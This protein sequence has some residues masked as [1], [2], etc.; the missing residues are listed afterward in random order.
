[1]SSIMEL[2][3]RAKAAKS[4]IANA[5]T[6]TKN[7][8]LYAI[9][10]E[11]DTQKESILQ[12]N[13]LDVETAKKNGISPSMLDRLSLTEA[14]IDG[15]RDAVLQL[16][17]LPD[18]VG[19]I[20]EGWT[21]PNGLSIRKVTVPL[22]V[23]GMIY[24]ARPNVTVDAATLCLKAG[25]AVMLR[26]GKEAFH[27]SR[28][29]AQLMRAAVQKAGLPEDIIT[30]VEQTD[31]ETAAEMMRL[32]GFLDVLIPRGGAGLIQTVVKTATVPVIET[33]TG[34]CHIF[35]DETADL[36]SAVKI[37]YNAKT[38]RPSV[39][40]A[41]ESLL[42]HQSAAEQFLPMVKLRSTR[43]RFSFTAVSEPG[44]F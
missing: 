5:D 31:R 42:V 6:R 19:R 27:S 2:G 4:A 37:V 41:A 14:R 28:C 21:V 29:L 44:Q 7:A 38:S 11:L 12:A 26:G 22:G 32:N 8:A 16:V 23:V 9:A 3:A 34:N 43:K 1:M 25:N 13:A 17:E 30:F 40:N 24:E 36:D 33:G 39:C 10:Q 18:P 15:I 20:L 35:V